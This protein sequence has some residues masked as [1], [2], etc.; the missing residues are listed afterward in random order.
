[1]RAFPSQL[2]GT[3][4]GCVRGWCP[5]LW[6]DRGGFGEV[7]RGFG[8]ARGSTCPD[9]CESFDMPDTGSEV[10]TPENQAII[11]AFVRELP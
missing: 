7:S 4:I 2:T 11:E 9:T 3:G 1:M 6:L 10:N 8:Q 5:N